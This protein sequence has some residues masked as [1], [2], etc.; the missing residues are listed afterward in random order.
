VLVVLVIAGT[1][2][3]QDGLAR[4]P[5]MGYNTWYDFMCKLN[6]ADVRGA[7]DALVEQGLTELGYNYVN[8]DDCWASGRF[9]NGT[10]FPNT[11]FPSGMKALADYVHALGLKFGVYTD[12]GTK[13]CAGFPGSQGYETVDANTY[14]AWGVDF[15]KEDSCYAV[16]DPVAAFPQYGKMRDALKATGRP[17]LFSLCGWN[18]WYAPNGDGLGHMWRIAGDGNSWKNVVQNMNVLANIWYCAGPGAWNDPDM[19]LGT[20][21]TSA[22]YLTQDQS[23]LQFSVWSVATVPLI[24]GSSILKLNPFDLQT[25]TNKF[26]IGVN[27]DPS[28][29]VG[30]RIAGN[31]LSFTT[32]LKTG[33]QWNVWSKT[34]PSGVAVLVFLN[35]ANVST[36]VTCDT[37]CVRQTG[38][39]QFAQQGIDVY[40]AWTN[41]TLGQL[42]VTIGWTAPR[43]NANGGSQTIVFAPHG[44][45]VF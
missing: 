34:L 3:I 37:I 16:N 23:R 27:Q 31:Q 40:D 44:H 33:T 29:V 7:A 28:G 6:E 20:S 2:A 14:A 38:I 17:I 10:V 39:Q 21:P 18:Q 12:R 25:Y 11:Q 36:S 32:D 22:I 13:T 45:K 43:V 35:I 26:L 1:H 4:T 15:L 41:Q 9:K 5:P 30:R 42:D 19:L 24:I 8:I